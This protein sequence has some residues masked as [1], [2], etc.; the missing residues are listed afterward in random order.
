M[1]KCRGFAHIVDKLPWS[2]RKRKEF[3][4]IWDKSVAAGGSGREIHRKQGRPL[5]AGGPE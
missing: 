4:R 5:V 2:P 1:D 3:D